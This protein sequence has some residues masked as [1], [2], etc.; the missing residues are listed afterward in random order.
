MMG[1]A[2]KS[3]K[4]LQSRAHVTVTTAGVVKCCK[5]LPNRKIT[6]NTLCGEYPWNHFSGLVKVSAQD[7]IGQSQ[8]RGQQEP[9]RGTSRADKFRLEKLFDGKQLAFE[10]RSKIAGFSSPRLSEGW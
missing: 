10:E 2:D 8:Y 4:P 9:C 7:R 3:A 1:E 5:D 6:K